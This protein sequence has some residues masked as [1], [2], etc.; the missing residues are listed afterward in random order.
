VWTVGSE[1]ATLNDGSGGIAFRFHARDLNLVMAPSA[2]GDAR[3][4]QLVRQAGP[5]GDRRFEIE[6]RDPG[7]R[8]YSFTFG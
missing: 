1:F 8:A 2:P 5:V 4:C 6:F 7:V 3:M